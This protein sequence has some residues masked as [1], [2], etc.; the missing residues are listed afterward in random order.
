[1][2]GSRDDQKSGVVG[3]TRMFYKAQ[4]VH[5]GPS[6]DLHWREMWQPIEFSD[7]NWWY[8]LKKG[9]GPSSFF[10]SR[11]CCSVIFYPSVSLALACFPHCKG[12][13]GGNTPAA[14]SRSTAPTAAETFAPSVWPRWCF[15]HEEKHP[16]GP[17]WLENGWLR[18]GSLGRVGTV[19]SAESLLFEP[20]ESWPQEADPQS[21]SPPRLEKQACL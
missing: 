3:D 9:R 18:G 14:S 6:V 20:S 15:V 12:L 2:G 11:L 16:Q 21:R 4:K 10:R 7:Q 1:M 13:D 5:V 17:H 19:R 8:P